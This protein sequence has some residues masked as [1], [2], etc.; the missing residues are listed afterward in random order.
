MAETNANNSGTGGSSDTGANEKATGQDSSRAS[1]ARARARRKMDDM[2]EEFEEMHDRFVG[3]LPEDFVGHMRAA[4][5]EMLLAM[6]SLI[7]VGVEK[8]EKKERRRAARRPTR[9]NVE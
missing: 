2:Q 3:M 7:D 4:Q 6:R 1:E 9:V 5:K 8:I